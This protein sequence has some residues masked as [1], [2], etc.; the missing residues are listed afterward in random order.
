MEEGVVFLPFCAHVC[1]ELVG[2]I[3]KL[4]EY[5]AITFVKKDE[6]PVHALWKVTM[7]I[8]ADVMQH[9]LGK[10]LDQEEIYC[11]FQPTD[12]YQSME[13]AHINKDDVMKMLLS[14]ED[15]EC[16]RMIR[17]RPQIGRPHV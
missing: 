1:K 4:S 17:L 9:R 2:G 15:F 10:R 16:V 12:I 7:S 11:T 5:F 3:K 8:E 13:D 6:L 14:I